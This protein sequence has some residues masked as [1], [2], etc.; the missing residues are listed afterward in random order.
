MP[1]YCAR[2][3]GVMRLAVLLADVLV[4]QSG[5]VVEL[6]ADAGPIWR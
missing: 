1:V 6:A 4:E 5:A 2:D 3:G